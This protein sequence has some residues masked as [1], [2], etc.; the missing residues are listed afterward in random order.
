MKALKAGAAV[1]LWLV[2]AGASWGHSNAAWVAANSPPMSP[3]A[4]PFATDGTR[5][6][7]SRVGGA[8]MAGDITVLVGEHPHPY[9]GMFHARVFWVPP[10]FD[11]SA[12]SDLTVNCSIEI[13]RDDR[14]DIRHLST[15]GEGCQDRHSTLTG[16]AQLLDPGLKLLVDVGCYE[17]VP[18][19]DDGGLTGCNEITGG[20]CNLKD[21]L[22]LYVK[23]I[24]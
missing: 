2:L 23:N 11:Y 15:Q 21:P 3:W 12:R 13:R 22:I 20:G 17:A 4:T 24:L 10:V 6:Q 1:L 5:L 7:V 16:L 9:D 19:F 14:I 18:T 8:R